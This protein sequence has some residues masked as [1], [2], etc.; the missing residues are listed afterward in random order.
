MLKA[1]AF[2]E[3]PRLFSVKSRAMPPLWLLFAVGAAS[4]LFL[5]SKPYESTVKA[6]PGRTLL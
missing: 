2:L 4:P 3:A 6:T 1:S 5:S